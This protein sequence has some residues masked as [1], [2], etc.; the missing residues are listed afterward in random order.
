MGICNG[1]VGEGKT[2]NLLMLLAVH[3][4]IPIGSGSTCQGACIPAE[5]LCTLPTQ[6]FR[7]SHDWMSCLFNLN[8]ILAKI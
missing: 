1:N 6:V 3:R 8:C 7:V 5:T 2:S 4:M